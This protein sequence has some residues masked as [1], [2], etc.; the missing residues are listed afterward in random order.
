MASEADRGFREHFSRAEITRTQQPT[1]KSERSNPVG[2]SS[3]GVTKTRYL[4]TKT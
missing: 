3:A 4:Q 1:L 2:H